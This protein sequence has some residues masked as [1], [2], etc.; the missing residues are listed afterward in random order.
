MKTKMVKNCVKILILVVMIV[1][2]GRACN[3]CDNKFNEP[4]PAAWWYRTPDV[5]RFISK[6]NHGLFAFV[7]E[8]DSEINV[9]LI[10]KIS[11]SKKMY[12][13]KNSEYHPKIEIC[14]ITSLSSVPKE[15]YLREGDSFCLFL[16]E[17]DRQVFYSIA[18]STNTIEWFEKVKFE[19]IETGDGYKVFNSNYLK[20]LCYIDLIE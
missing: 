13:M 10:V 16:R 19:C 5:Q 20:E 17:D 2:M 18:Y 7:E 4:R 1:L 9:K 3:S 12:L 6:G 11:C 15:N 8:Q 14:D